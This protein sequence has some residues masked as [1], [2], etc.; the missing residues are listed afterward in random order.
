MITK[1]KNPPQDSEN[2]KGA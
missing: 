2:F 1:E